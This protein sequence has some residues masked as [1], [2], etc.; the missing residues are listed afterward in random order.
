M[1]R[2][3][4]Y[5]FSL[6]VKRLQQPNLERISFL[7]SSWSPM[8]L[9]WVFLNV[10]IYSVVEIVDERDFTMYYSL[11]CICSKEYASLRHLPFSPLRGSPSWHHVTSTHLIRPKL[12]VDWILNRIGFGFAIEAPT[13][14][15]FGLSRRTEQVIP[16]P[17]SRIPPYG[18]RAVNRENSS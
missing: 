8:L 7:S 13:L 4:R 3:R 1:R 18:S 10:V 14:R 5:F 9:R 11:V 17:C 12:M 6:S 15:L 16:I 2:R